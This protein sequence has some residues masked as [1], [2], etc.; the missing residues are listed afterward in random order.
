MNIKYCIRLPLKTSQYENHQNTKLYTLI[1]LENFT[2][3]QATYPN[4]RYWKGLFPFQYLCPNHVLKLNSYY[5]THTQT[6][7]KTNSIQNKTLNKTVIVYA[8]NQTN[9]SN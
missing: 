6:Y 3:A 1:D 2:H 8:Y 7:I 4:H 5:Q 9:N